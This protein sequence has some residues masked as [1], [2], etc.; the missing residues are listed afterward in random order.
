MNEDDKY[1]GPG[2]FRFCNAGYHLIEHGSTC[3]G[4][5]KEVEKVAKIDRKWGNIA[6]AILSEIRHNIAQARKAAGVPPLFWMK[7]I[8]IED[9]P[10]H[11]DSHIIHIRNCC[12]NVDCR[13]SCGS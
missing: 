7:G 12:N 13:T 2:E 11:Y 1:I 6:H 3:L 5:S 4:C 9:T 8:K 10:K